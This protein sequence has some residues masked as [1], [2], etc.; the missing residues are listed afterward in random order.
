M[1]E[2]ECLHL[3]HALL[4]SQRG[5][6]SPWRRIRVQP[7]TDRRTQMSLTSS[8]GS[9]PPQNHRSCETAAR[10]RRTWDQARS[11]W[12]RACLGGP[13]SN[14]KLV[15]ACQR[16]DHQFLLKYPER[17]RRRVVKDNCDADSEWLRTK[18]GRAWSIRRCRLW[19]VRTFERSVS[20]LQ[21]TSEQTA[22]GTGSHQSTMRRSL[23]LIRATLARFNCIPGDALERDDHASKMKARCETMEQDQHTS[24]ASALSRKPR[25][26]ESRC[27]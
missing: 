19:C 5:A 27:S 4:L 16:S 18:P 14:C 10:S 12:R 26:S 8:Q 24:E 15:A 9:P 6:H 2:G 20:F 23:P 13:C 21:L 25:S 22:T 17:S 3:A 7:D 11:A 1:L